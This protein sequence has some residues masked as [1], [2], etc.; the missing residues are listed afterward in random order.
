M[1]AKTLSYKILLGHRRGRDTAKL[2]CYYSPTSWRSILLREED[3]TQD[4]SQFS[5]VHN[6]GLV[7]MNLKEP[8]R[9][10]C[11]SELARKNGRA[12]SVFAKACFVLKGSPVPDCAR[13]E[14]LEDLRKVVRLLTP[15]TEFLIAR[16]RRQ[17]T[18]VAPQPPAL[19]L[20]IIPN[21]HSRSLPKSSP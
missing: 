19:A 11:N 4:Q 2:Y 20:S 21:L 9:T 16:R 14:T 8:F 17:N 7:E 5:A 3:D 18:T 15:D 12:L 6:R 13:Y 10:I 1:P